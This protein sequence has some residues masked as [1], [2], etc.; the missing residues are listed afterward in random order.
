MF[1]AAGWLASCPVATLLLSSLC[2]LRIAILA[3]SESVLKIV[4]LLQSAEGP[5]NGND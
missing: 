5:L 2:L 3:D 1:A 4:L